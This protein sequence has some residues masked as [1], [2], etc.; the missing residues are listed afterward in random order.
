MRR[1]Q[2]NILPEVES[3][4]TPAVACLAL[5]VHSGGPMKCIPVLIACHLG[6][7]H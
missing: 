1:M 2:G 6:D 4:F 7:K 3:T 5:L